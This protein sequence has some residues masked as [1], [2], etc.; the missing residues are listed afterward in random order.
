MKGKNKEN[1]HNYYILIVVSFFLLIDFSFTQSHQIDILSK[2]IKVE[3][4]KILKEFNLSCLNDCSFNGY[5]AEG[6][7][8]CKPGFDGEDCSKSH[9]PNN[10]S[11][12]GECLDGICNCHKDFGGPGCNISN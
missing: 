2:R 5:C 11:G 3:D 7:C 6:V 1:I 12:N 4:K 8:H 9:C 10:C